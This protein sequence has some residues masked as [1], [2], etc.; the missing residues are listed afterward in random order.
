MKYLET[1]QLLVSLILFNSQT[2]YLSP[3]GQLYLAAQ[4]TEQNGYDK[5]EN[6]S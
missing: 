5:Q 6:N 3:Q 1:C 4:N 2:L